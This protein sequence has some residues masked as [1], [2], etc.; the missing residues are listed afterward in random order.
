MFEQIDLLGIDG[1]QIVLFFGIDQLCIVCM[2]QC[3]GRCVFVLVYLG[4]GM[5]YVVQ[6]VGGQWVC[7]VYVDFFWVSDFS[8]VIRC[9]I[10]V[11]VCRVDRLMCS[12]VVFLGIVGG[13]I[14]GVQMFLM[15]RVV[16]RV[17]VVVL[18]FM[19]RGWM[20]VGEGSSVYGSFVS[21][22]CNCLVSICRCVCCYFLWVIRCRLVEVVVVSVGGCVVLNMQVWVCC[23]IYVSMLVLLVM[24]V[25]VIL[26]V[27]FSVFISSMCGVC[28]FVR[29]RLF[30]F[31]G[32]S[33]F[34]LW[35]LFI[36]SQVLCWVYIVVSLVNGVRLLF[37]L[38]MVLV[39]ISL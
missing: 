29:V 26:V 27:L 31:C 14:V 18:L 36:S 10:L 16:E 28:M 13:Q 15:C 9:V 33:M 30:C 38:N 11:G 37:M 20:V 19:I 22:L 35:V 7:Y 32:L 21:L 25:L 34:R 6:V 8:V 2:G 5:L 1:I 3:D 23:R 17:W 4:V 12:W 24:K 39:S